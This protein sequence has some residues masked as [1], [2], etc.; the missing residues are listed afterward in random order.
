MNSFPLPGKPTNPL[1]VHDV[2]IIGAGPAGLSAALLLARCRR[3]VFIIDSNE[4]R[5]A[6]S[7]SLHGF[8]TRDGVSPHE[9]RERGR[10]DLARYPSVTFHHGRV[11]DARRVADMFEV[12]ADAG[13]T[14][15][16]RLLLLA[17]GRVD[18][19]PEVPG[20]HAYYGR[21]VYHCPLCDGWEHRD[22]R[23]AM[24]GN[25]AR[26]FNIARELLTWSEQV[27]ICC[28]GP[29]EWPGQARHAAYLGIGV[30]TEPIQRLEGTSEGLSRICFETGDPLPCDALYFDGEC[31]QR[32][33]LPE[34]L[35]C[36]FDEENAVLCSR[37]AATHV[38]GLYIAGNVRGGLHLAI[39]AAAEGAQAAIAMNDALL[40]QAYP[41]FSP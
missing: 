34:R 7:P 9:L 8:L 36:H 17:T 21:G 22:R 24:Y 29:P 14:E 26:A 23:L 10:A 32:S 40:D 37:H 25:G 11:D 28:G 39:S 13:R 15:R 19:I 5:N 41:P 4:P 33:S 1:V 2:I 20:F 6:V 12:T 35:G 30:V 3:T 18:V 38:P 27:T 16:S 31:V